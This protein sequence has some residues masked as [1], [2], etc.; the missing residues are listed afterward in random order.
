MGG[1]EWSA[2]PLLF[3][4]Y[5]VKDPENMIARLA[6]IRDKVNTPP[7]DERPKHDR[8]KAQNHGKR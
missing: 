6:I 2:L 8:G 1:L 3:A 7:D 5:D 4:V